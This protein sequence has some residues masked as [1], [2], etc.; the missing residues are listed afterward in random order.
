MYLKP[1]KN[2]HG[3]KSVVEVGKSKHMSDLCMFAFI[4]P[5]ILRL[6]TM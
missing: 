5:Y 2:T 4:V 3:L 1:S 6:E